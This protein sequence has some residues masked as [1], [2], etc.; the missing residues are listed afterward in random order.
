ML[1]QDDARPWI[2]KVWKVDIFEGSVRQIRSQLNCKWLILPCIYKLSTSIY[3]LLCYLSV[4]IFLNI[5]KVLGTVT[6]NGQKMTRFISRKLC[7]YVSQYDLHHA[8]MTVKETIGFSR[9]MLNAGNATGENNMLL[10]YHTA[11]RI[12]HWQYKKLSKSHT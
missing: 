6:Y 12:K 8:E 11:L 7:A 2:S 9:K 3:C 1:F 5:L 10:D 4:L